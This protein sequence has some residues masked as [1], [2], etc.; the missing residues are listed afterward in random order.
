M[1][2]KCTIVLTTA[3]PTRRCGLAFDSGSR[4]NTH[5]PWQE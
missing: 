1:N 5:P 2:T 4:L 3:P